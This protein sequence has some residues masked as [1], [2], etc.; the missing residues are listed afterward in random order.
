MHIVKILFVI[1]VTV[2]AGCSSSSSCIEIEPNQVVFTKDYEEVLLDDF[3]KKNHYVAFICIDASCSSC[4]TE[5]QWW[6]KFIDEHKL[7]SPVFVINYSYG[8]IQ[9]FVK[10]VRNIIQIEYPVIQEVDYKFRVDNEMSS[11]DTILISQGK[12][13]IFCGDTFDKDFKK[14]YNQLKTNKR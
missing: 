4:M 13:V 5:L 11:E 2:I 7:L 6:Y 14:F 1:A 10:Y 12:K 8:S 9:P 3:V